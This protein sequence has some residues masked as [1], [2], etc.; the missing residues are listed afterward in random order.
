VGDDIHSPKVWGIG[1]RDTDFE[2]IKVKGLDQIP[3]EAEKNKMRPWIT[4]AFTPGAGR[5]LAL[6]LSN[7]RSLSFLL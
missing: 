7:T 1:P 4:P 3:R 6:F 2:V 5:A